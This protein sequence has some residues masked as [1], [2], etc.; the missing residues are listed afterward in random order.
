MEFVKRPNII[1]INCDDMGY[2]DPGCYGSAVNRT[3]A[4]D[5]L[6]AEGMLFTDFYMASPVCSPS[7]GAMLTGCYPPR[8]GFGSFEGQWVLFPGHAVGLSPDELTIADILRKEGYRTKIIGKWHCGDQPEFLPLNHGFDEYYGLPYSN[9]MGR[10][11]GRQNQMPPLPLI[12]DDA[13]IQQQPDQRSLTERYT[14]QALEF[15]E[16]NR[17]GPFFLYFAHMHVHLPL[18]AAECFV[19]ESKNGDYGACMASVDWSVD[20]LMHKLEKENLSE[21]TIIIFTSDNGG[22][23]DNGGSNFPLRGCKTTTWEGGMRVPCIMRW[24]RGIPAGSVCPDIFASIDLLPTIAALCGV[25][26][27]NMPKSKIDGLDLSA[28]C[29]GGAGNEAPKR[30]TFF[31]YRQ[32]ALEAVRR[33]DWKLHIRKDGEAV[34]LLYNLREDISEQHDVCEL[35]PDIAEQLEKSA[36]NC[37]IELG[38]EASGIKGAEVRPIGRVADARPLTEYDENHP[39]IIAMYDKT[40]AG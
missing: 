13:V 38:D 28:L 15:I 35:Y 23:G 22:R 21:N 26:D 2:G 33:R 19:N 17:G 14:E 30:E 39:Y 9:D 32:N 34:R 3:P 16:R 25:S 31:Y 40:E 1:L 8:I 20:C 36:Q 6:A 37:R 24:P 4:I 5:R 12:K 29:T 11:A 10:Q 27:S 18:Y 7:R